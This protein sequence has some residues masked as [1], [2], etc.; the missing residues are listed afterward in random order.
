MRKM[1]SKKQ[2]EEIA[3]SSGPKLYKH[4]LV[5]SDI[6][7]AFTLIITDSQPIDFSTIDTYSKLHDFLI[8]K[9]LLLFIDSIDRDEIFYDRESGKFFAMLVQNINNNNICT[10]SYYDDWPLSSTTDT[11]TPL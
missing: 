8:S 11:V 7:Y 3:K 4:N 6:G 1:Y 10:T 9:N 5:A 2:I